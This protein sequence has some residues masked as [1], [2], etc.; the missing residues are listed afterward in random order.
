[1]SRD[2]G[3]KWGVHWEDHIFHW[4]AA[5]LPPAPADCCGL[6][7]DPRYRFDAELVESVIL[8]MKRRKAAGLRNI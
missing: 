7:G 4:G 6:P 5:P 3:P 1:M 2:A 8:K